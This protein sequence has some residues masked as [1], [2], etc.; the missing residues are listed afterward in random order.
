M[1]SKEELITENINEYKL[2]ALFITETWQ[3]NTVEDEMWL[4]ASEFCKDDHEI[5]N[6]NGT[7]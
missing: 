4:Q 2:D 3:Q 7:G 5:S 6:I 1:K